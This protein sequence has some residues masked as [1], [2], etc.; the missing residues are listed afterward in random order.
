ML[1]GYS[2]WH[3]SWVVER[4]PLCLGTPGGEG[5]WGGRAGP[6]LL[7]FLLPSQP[8]LNKGWDL[9]RGP[10]LRGPGARRPSLL[11]QGCQPFMPSD[12]DPQAWSPMRELDLGYSLSPGGL[13]EC[14][15]GPRPDWEQGGP[16][17]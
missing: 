5:D 3:F 15:Q 8:F 6:S 11:P 2:C 1:W 4:R 12:Q 7:I 13:G 10:K 14:P 16:L 17:G 9:C